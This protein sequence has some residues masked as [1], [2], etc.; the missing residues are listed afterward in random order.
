MALVCAP[1]TTRPA[2][3]SP[4]IPAARVSRSST[5]N[6]DDRLPTSLLEAVA[7][8]GSSRTFRANTILINEGDPG[9]FALHRPR[10][11]PARLRELGRGTRR[12]PRRSTVRASTSASSRSTA[13]ARSAS[14]KTVEA[15]T[16]CVVQGPQLHELPCRSSRVRAAPVAEAHAHG[17]PPDRA[18]EEPRAAGRLRANG[19]AADG[20]LGA[21]R[22]GTDRA[23]E[24]DPA[25]HRRPRRLV[26]RNGQPG[27][28]GADDRRLRRACAT[29]G[30]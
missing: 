15:T 25:G 10:R 5:V 23:R 4:W 28:E 2:H 18:G 22:R 30:T 24:A 14:V 29:A 11:A 3:N 1:P 27:D 13:S 17:P 21:G 7:A 6:T 20:A 12:R 16:C 19:A 8:H 9:G 26:A